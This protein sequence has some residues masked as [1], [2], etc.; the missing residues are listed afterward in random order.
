M[1]EQ[2]QQALSTGDHTTAQHLIRQ[3]S[4][5]QTSA[6]AQIPL[7]NIC[8]K[9]GYYDLSVQCF[10]K[11]AN[12]EKIALQ[13]MPLIKEPTI[14]KQTELSIALLKVAQ[15]A[16]PNNLAIITAYADFLLANNRPL[17]VEALLN[18]VI[19][20]SPHPEILARLAEAHYRLGKFHEA[21]ACALLAMEMAPSNPQSYINLAVI[22]KALHNLADAAKNF[23]RALQLDG[24]NFFA[25]INLAQLSLMTGQFALGWQEY[26]WRWHDKNCHQEQPP[27]PL[28]DGECLPEQHLLLW[29]DQGLGDQIMF[30]SLLNRIPCR[31]T[32]KVDPR[33][34][35]LLP[36]DIGFM[37]ADYSGDYAEF[38]AHLSLGSLPYYFIHRFADFS[39]RDY[40]L[41]ADAKAVNLHEAEKRLV[42]FSW[43]G[44]RFGT[45]QGLRSLPFSVWEN[46]LTLDGIQWVNLQYDT[47]EEERSWLANKGVITPDCDLKNDLVK[48][49][50]TMLNLER[51]IGVD[52]SSV[53][54]AGAL[55]VPTNLLL[56]AIA[57]WR[58]FTEAEHCYWYKSVSLHRLLP[59]QT[60]SG[61]D[62]ITGLQRIIT[63]DRG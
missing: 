19:N 52:N 56:T 41:T 26:E 15:Q 25:H 59:L 51:F 20:R 50:A 39:P 12:D 4:A 33:L 53:H 58:W 2:L 45:E 55:G 43:R 61:S 24:D 23:R 49:A 57:D 30:L 34:Q 35:P 8:L 13:V 37:A 44:G 28:W 60:D 3:I 11:A 5:Q 38:D 63:P 17:Q 6:Q 22:E 27:L 31:V 18:D 48:I 36:A 54:L 14:Q 42:G 10:A 1:I 21:K 46:L 62:F 29:A 32:V 47:T 7:V 40:F 9:H 16:Q